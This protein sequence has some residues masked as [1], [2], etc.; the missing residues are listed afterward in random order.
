MALT[1]DD[2]KKAF[3]GKTF[4]EGDV[5]TDGSDQY[6]YNKDGNFEASSESASGTSKSTTP[7]SWDGP[8]D[9]RELPGA[10]KYPNFYAHKTRSGHVLL[11]DDS[12]GAEHVTLQHRSGSMVQFHPDG[13]VAITAQNGQY[14]FT[15]GE[16][17]VKITGAYDITVD[18]AA[19]MKVDG[20]YNVTV[21]KNMNIAV[22]G[23]LNVAAKNFNQNMIG[24]VDIA[25]KNMTTK[26]EGSS[27][28]TAKGSMGLTSKGGFVAGSVDDSSTLYA[29]KQMA[30][31]AD[32]DEMMIRSGKKMSFE[33]ATGDIAVQ[34]LEGAFSVL[35][36]Q[37]VMTFETTA[38]I[39]TTAALQLISGAFAS[40]KAI[41]QVSLLGGAAGVSIGGIGPVSMAA[42]GPLTLGST[43]TTSIKSPLTGITSTA[44]GLNA[45]NITSA[46]I[47]QQNGAV[48]VVPFVDVVPIPPIPEIPTL[49][50][51]PK[52]EF[53]VSSAETAETVD[54]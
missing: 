26:L 10:G 45:T 16:N 30:L 52:L 18:G 49:A 34:T 19:S 23:D 48:L 3:P 25:A 38:T 51:N 39:E 14:T 54:V 31:L 6:T 1:T 27:A 36:L 17:R 12:K 21:G 47:I 15:F 7:P 53:N 29:G 37:G 4:S 20:D 43:T 13:K 44:I 33:S 2:I 11:M 22:K 24:N 46:G 8:K 40:L 35:A 32:T 41:G 9:A 28:I 42:V 5:V 50:S